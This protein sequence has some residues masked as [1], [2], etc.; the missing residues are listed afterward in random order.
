MT[1]QTQGYF[2]VNFFK[3]VDLWIVNLE[4]DIRFSM[5]PML[6]AS[7]LLHFSIKLKN[8]LLTAKWWQVFFSVDSCIFDMDH[9][10]TVVFMLEHLEH[11]IRFQDLIKVGCLL[12]HKTKE[13]HYYIAVFILA[14]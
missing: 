7:N 1:S 2:H 13:K 14:Q 3:S 4:Y 12:F 9:R 8:N 5:R 10:E 6:Y 11:L